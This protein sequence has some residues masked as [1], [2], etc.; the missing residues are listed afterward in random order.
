[1]KKNKKVEFGDRVDIEYCYCCHDENISTMPLNNKL[2]FIL[3][4]NT[5]QPFI[6]NSVLNMQSGEY[7]IVETVED[8]S[9]GLSKKHIIY[10]IKVVNVHK[11][12]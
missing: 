4:K 10:M 6:E 5:A 11:K 9:E 1:M 2:S 8:E 12:K 3:G 7:T